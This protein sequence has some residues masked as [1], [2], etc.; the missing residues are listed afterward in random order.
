MFHRTRPYVDARDVAAEFY[1]RILDQ[2]EA[3]P[4]NQVSYWL[5]V[6]DVCNR[7]RQD[8]AAKF[9]SSMA[10][11]HPDHRQS[12]DQEAERQKFE[13]EAVTV[14]LRD[15]LGLARSLGDDGLLRQIYKLDPSLAPPAA[16]SREQRQRQGELVDAFNEKAAAVRSLLEQIVTLMGE[17]QEFVKA[18]TELLRGTSEEQ[19]PKLR[20]ELDSLRSDVFARLRSGSSG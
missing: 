5:T 8:V 18:E 17:C 3:Q 7:I 19:R 20:R 4:L 6:A 12:I 11:V 10:E 9:N 1:N 16:P 2:R 14:F 13:E 15:V